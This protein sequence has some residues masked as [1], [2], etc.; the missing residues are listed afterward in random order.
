MGTKKIKK[1]FLKKDKRALS[2]IVAYVLLIVIAVSIS[3]L[4]YKWLSLQ[5]P[6]EKPECPDG[7]SVSVASYECNPSGLSKVTIIFQNK[8]TFDVSALYVKASSDKNAP[9]SKPLPAIYP[10]S[11]PDLDEVE[12]GFVLFELIKSGGKLLPGKERPVE[13]NYTNF[14]IPNTSPKIEKIQITPLVIS[15]KNRVFCSEQTISAPVECTP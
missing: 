15:G 13:F 12:P 7:L 5:I 11:I 6:K 9:A 3:V 8:G 14:T 4:V 2:E 1:S 10:S